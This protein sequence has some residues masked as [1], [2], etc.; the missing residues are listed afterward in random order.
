MS[1]E[2]RQFRISKVREVGSPEVQKPISTAVIDARPWRLALRFVMQD[3]SEDFGSFATGAPR[4]G[5]GNCPNW[6]RGPGAVALNYHK[7]PR[8]SN[9]PLAPPLPPPASSPLLLGSRSLGPRSSGRGIPVTTGF[10]SPGVRAFPSSGFRVLG[11]PEGR[12]V[13]GSKVRMV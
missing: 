6:A 5:G 10:M 7:I 3:R 1:P 8:T 4:A 13:T 11:S 12:Q 2:V 9:F